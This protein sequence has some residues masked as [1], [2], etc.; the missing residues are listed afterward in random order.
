MAR[1]P[2][3]RLE[4]GV[5]HVLN[6]AHDGRFVFEQ[7]VDKLKFLELL[8]KHGEGR[9]VNV[10]NWVIMSNHFHLSIET[11]R[12]TDLSAYI[13]KVCELYTRHYHHRHGGA[14]TLWQARFK[15]VLVQKNAYMAQ[16]GRYIDRN[17]VRAEMCDV[18]WDY[19]WSSA[20]AYVNGADDQLVRIDDNWFYQSMG[21]TNLARSECYRQYL[22]DEHERSD[23][24]LLFK[25][26]G[27]VV[28]NDAFT[29]AA[30][31]KSGRLTN[32]RRGPKPRVQ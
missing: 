2:R 15:S 17:P 23:D 28:G 19:P 8:V 20:R 22:L 30:L 32:R 7:D 24:E 27:P 1:V 9:P 11:T 21:E 31:L 26:S 13:G 18:P 6:R 14:G 10:Y 29:A 25:D 16:L 12:M 4:D 5:F 3:H